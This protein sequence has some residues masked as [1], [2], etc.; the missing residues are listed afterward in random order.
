MI[1]EE[2]IEQFKSIEKVIEE[3]QHSEEFFVLYRFF[4]EF[5]GRNDK[6]SEYDGQDAEPELQTR[7]SN[8]EQTCQE[9]E[10]IDYQEQPV[11]STPLVRTYK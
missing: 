1:G 2:R 10:T 8:L 4:E 3:K 7:E 11:L 6:N 5:A 9:Q